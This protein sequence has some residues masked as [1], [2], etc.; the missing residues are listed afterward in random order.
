MRFGYFKL[1]SIFL[2]FLLVWLCIRFFLPLFF[3][4]LLG[5]LLAVAAEPVTGLLQN[6]F[7]MPRFLCSGIGVSMAFALLALILMI[8]GALAV[9]EATRLVTILPQARQMVQ[10]GLLSAQDFLLSLSQNLP[11]GL[12]GP[13]TQAVMELFSGGAA[14]LSRITDKLLG[15]A[16]GLLGR[17]LTILS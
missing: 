7:H 11:D 2:V 15:L 14:F 9:K 1:P 16:T 12:S 6:K 10:A 4:F 5:A 8:L 13:T 3:P 17:F